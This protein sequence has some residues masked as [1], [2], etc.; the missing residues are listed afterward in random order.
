MHHGDEEQ[1]KS[2]S[3]VSTQASQLLS[4]CSD[5]RDGHNPRIVESMM[6][7]KLPR[8]Q[9]GQRRI[10]G[11]LNQFQGIYVNLNI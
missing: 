9:E 4:R 10:P 8:M 3:S 2:L 11:N 6:W 1:S 5:Y 7:I